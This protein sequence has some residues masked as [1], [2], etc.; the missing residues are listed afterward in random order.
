MRL[1]LGL[2]LFAGCRVMP[3][4]VPA[5]PT[6]CVST[7]A[8]VWGNDQGAY[9]LPHDSLAPLVVNQSGYTPDLEAWNALG[10][11]IELRAEGTGF[12][13]DVTEGG[14]ADSGWLG[15]ASINIAGGHITR[16]TVTMNRA[17]LGRYEPVVAAHVLCQ[18]LGHLLGLDHQRLADDSCMDDC[19]GRTD[20][21]GCLS[22]PAGTTPNAH[23]REQLK[24]IYA[25]TVPEGEACPPVPRCEG[26]LLLHTFGVPSG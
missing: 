3:P 7:E 24:A 17:V 1:F 19:Q 5:P 18:E 12:A 22:A 13:I 16:A 10:T 2:L 26:S 8:H 25:H 6:E 14:D 21:L 20:W 23:D 9:H 15:L 4:N 11:P